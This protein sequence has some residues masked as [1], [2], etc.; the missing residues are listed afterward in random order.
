MSKPKRKGCGETFIMEDIRYIAHNLGKTGM[1]AEKIA[2]VLETD[3]HTVASWLEEA[4]IDPRE[5]KGMAY[6]RQMAGIA[7]AKEKGVRFGRSRIEPPD[8]FPEIVDALENKEITAKEAIRQ[9]GM[10]EATFYRRLR[11]YREKRSK[12]N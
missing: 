5:Y 4:G 3:V 1:S 9:S 6:R 2:R 10:A 12:H 7:A 8:N 11:E